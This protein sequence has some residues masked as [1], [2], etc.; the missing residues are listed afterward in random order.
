MNGNKL[1]PCQQLEFRKILGACDVVLTISDRIQRALDSGFDV[2]M[3]EL[4]CSATFDCF[5]H[6]ALICKLRQL[7]IGGPFLDIL[8][9]PESSVW[10]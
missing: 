9:N 5:N 1:L 8:I 7:G 4:D 3:V 10:L 6:K 2:R